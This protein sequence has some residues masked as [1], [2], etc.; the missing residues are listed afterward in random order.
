MEKKEISTYEFQFLIGK[1]QTLLEQAVLGSF[2]EVSIPY[3]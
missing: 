2:G 1:L 3:R